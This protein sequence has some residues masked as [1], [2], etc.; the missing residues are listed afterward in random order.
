MGKF[1]TLSSWVRRLDTAC[2]THAAPQE[3]PCRGSTLY[4]FPCKPSEM[5][6]WQTPAAEQS[7]YCSLELAGTKYKTKIC[8][9][10]GEEPVRSG[11]GFSWG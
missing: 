11:L 7:S 8:K 2:A 4:V 1:E 6:Y 9:E 5:F 3:L 10:G